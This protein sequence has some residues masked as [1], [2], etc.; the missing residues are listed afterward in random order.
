M[1]RPEHEPTPQE[2]ELVVRLASKG[3]PQAFIAAKIGISDDTLRKQYERELSIAYADQAVDLCGAMYEK[4]IIER[5][6]TMII[7]MTK[8]LLGWRGDQGV[9][10]DAPKITVVLNRGQTRKSKRSTIANTGTD[11]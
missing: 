9:Q 4:A 2:R 8:N 7:W 6:T 11:G 1:A 10:Q 5:D 3:V